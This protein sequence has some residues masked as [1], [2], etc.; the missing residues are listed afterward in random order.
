MKTYNWGIL[1][2]ARITEEFIPAL[3]YVERAKVY[4]IASRDEAKARAAA[5]RFGAQKAYGSYEQMLEDPAVDIV[6]IAT[7]TSLH[8]E[9][10]KQC[11]S[12]GKPVLCEKAVTKNLAQFE[13]LIALAKEKNV[14]FM[15]GV[16]MKFHPA[17]IQAKRWFD[18]GKIGDLRV[19]KAE[20]GWSHAY[21]GND[22]IFS[23]ALGASTL[24]D[25][26]VY[27]MGLATAYMGYNPEKIQGACYKAPDGADID[28]SILLQKGEAYAALVMGNSFNAGGETVIAGK[29]G[30][31]VFTE[32][33][34][35][36]QRVFLYDDQDE[37][38]QVFDEPFGCNGFEMEIEHVHE[39]LD[40]GRMQSDVVS[41]NESRA[42]MRLIGRCMNVLGLD[43]GQK[44]EDEA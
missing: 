32:R 6:Y 29:K 17:F 35:D 23:K 9:H 42:M 1:S 10:A 39:C 7:P 31:I 14:F 24:L 18:E 11:L 2:T 22:R 25:L 34:H 8:F 15:E 41:W 33:F 16:W 13:E 19:V 26:G 36:A 4:A 5:E 21:D 3:Q 20:L 30:R 43:Y 12:Y 38:A 28:S 27:T 40:E 37:I 44:K